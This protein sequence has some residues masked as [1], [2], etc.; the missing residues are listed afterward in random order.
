MVS[1]EEHGAIRGNNGLEG[2]ARPFTQDKSAS[3]P[4]G[5]QTHTFFR[6]QVT[7]L[8]YPVCSRNWRTKR[9][10]CQQHLVPWPPG[11]LQIT[12]TPMSRGP[13]PTPPPS[14]FPT[15]RTDYKHHCRQHSAV[16][17]VLNSASFDFDHLHSELS[18]LK[19]K[20]GS[21][22]P[23]YSPQ[24]QF[25]NHGVQAPA[26][27]ASKSGGGGEDTADLIT[28][29]PGPTA[30]SDFVFKVFSFSANK[31]GLEMGPK[32]QHAAQCL[33]YENTRRTRHI[34]LGA[35]VTHPAQD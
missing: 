7:L 29:I 19:A 34:T 18:S 2:L 35:T 5:G 14:S 1:G 13:V 22:S 25:S 4:S 30:L 20:A 16:P 21:Y 9:S 8:L 6:A 10:P 28:L 15:P 27:Q 33:V 32:L 23:S 31:L 11:S 3:R 12:S 24:Q 17:T 26:E